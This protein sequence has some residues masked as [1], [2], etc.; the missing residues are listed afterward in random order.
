[1]LPSKTQAPP[2][3]SCIPEAHAAVLA[4]AA[5]LQVG[6]SLTA[7]AHDRPIDHCPAKGR[8]PLAPALGTGAKLGH[9]DDAVVAEKGQDLRLLGRQANTAWVCRMCGFQPWHDRAKANKASRNA[10]G[11]RWFSSRGICGTG[12]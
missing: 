9:P 4:T 3:C 7:Q 5:D 1:M 12:L 8:N 10:G 6:A 11:V 2:Q